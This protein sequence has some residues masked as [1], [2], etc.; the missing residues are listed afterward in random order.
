MTVAEIS[1]IPQT[2]V[3]LST[4]ESIRGMNKMLDLLDDDDDVQV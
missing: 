1:M 2:R 4:P 3:R